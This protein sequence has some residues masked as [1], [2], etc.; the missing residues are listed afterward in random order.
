MGR[1]ARCSLK[2]LKSFDGFTLPAKAKCIVLDERGKGLSTQAL[3]DQ[4]QHWQEQGTQE[5]VVCLGGADGVGPELRDNAD[6]V[7]SFGPQT[8]MH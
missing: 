4:V 3:S 1:Y 8:L 6:L 7:L 2:P 5:I